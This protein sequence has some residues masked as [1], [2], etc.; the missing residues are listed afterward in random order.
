[1]YGFETLSHVVK[2]RQNFAN[3]TIA[4]WEGI[5][6]G[7]SCTFTVALLSSGRWKRP[8][9]FWRRWWLIHFKSAGV[10]RIHHR[11]YSWLK[12]PWWL[13]I[14]G[15]FLYQGF[16]FSLASCVGVNG[17]RYVSML[18]TLLTLSRNVKPPH[19]SCKNNMAELLYVH[20]PLTGVLLPERPANLAVHR[21]IQS[22]KAL[23]VHT[24]RKC[25][26]IFILL[27]AAFSPLQ[28]KK[29]ELQLI[30]KKMGFS[31]KLW[32]CS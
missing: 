6:K 9:A 3:A 7:S 15:R 14:P 2:L 12:P 23:Q 1:M 10:G 31:L 8:R 4:P 24:R 16:L 19:W 17:H 18:Q 30:G 25:E 20:W 28:R 27:P 22:S 21:F 32:E 13:D 29:L 5:L 26:H 11:P